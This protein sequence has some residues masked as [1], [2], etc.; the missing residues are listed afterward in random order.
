MKCRSMSVFSLL[1][2]VAQLR[3]YKKIETRMLLKTDDDRQRVEEP[4]GLI[5]DV[6]V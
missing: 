5:P 4:R 1:L 6:G 3:N 2:M